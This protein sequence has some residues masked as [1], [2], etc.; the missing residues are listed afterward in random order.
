MKTTMQMAIDSIKNTAEDGTFDGMIKIT[1]QVVAEELE[2][3]LDTE[4]QNMELAFISGIGVDRD[5]DKWYEQT[6]GK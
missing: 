5:F 6:F 2:M 4:K 3:L 1:L